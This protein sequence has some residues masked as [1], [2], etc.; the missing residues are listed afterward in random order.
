MQ[1]AVTLACGF[2]APAGRACLPEGHWVGHRYSSEQMITNN[3]F[4]SGHVTI[5]LINSSYG[6][7]RRG[8]MWCCN[9]M[10]PGTCQPARA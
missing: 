3:A 5:L 1:D 7:F 9:I 4:K 10:F 6:E 2:M 8:S